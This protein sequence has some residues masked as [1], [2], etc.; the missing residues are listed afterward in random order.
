MPVIETAATGLRRREDLLQAYQSWAP[1]DDLYIADQLAPDLQV[2][3]MDGTYGFVPLNAYITQHSNIRRAYNAPART[4]GWSPSRQNWSLNMYAFKDLATQ[5]DARH[6]PEFEHDEIITARCA[7]QIKRQIELDVA[8]VITNATLF[9]ASG[10]T[11]LAITGGQEWSNAA[12]A[13]PIG[14]ITRAI[15]LLRN[16]GRPIPNTLVIN[17]TTWANL[18][19]CSQIK[20]L[21]VVSNYMGTAGA[22]EAYLPGELL[23]AALGIRRVLV[24]DLSY[25]DEASGNIVQAYPSNQ[26]FLCKV[27]SSSDLQ[28]PG[29]LRKLRMRGVPPVAIRSWDNPDPLGRWILAEEVLSVH[30]HPEASA[31][32]FANVST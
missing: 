22:K 26:A 28:S 9:P 20:N 31:F 17:R 21:T 12:N 29:T 15:E 6:Y 25:R 2:S 10:S 7:A 4:A 30:L 27:S 23:A 13:D 19:R 18:S 1:E 8:S 3:S 11:G 16:A 5:D 14:N 32:R 24:S